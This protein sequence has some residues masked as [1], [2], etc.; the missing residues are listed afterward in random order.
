MGCWLP[1]AIDQ[2]KTQAHWVWPGVCHSTQK[3]LTD[4]LH[5]RELPKHKLGLVIARQA[6][7]LGPVKLCLSGPDKKPLARRPSENHVNPLPA[8]IFDQ[9]IRQ[10]F[11]PYLNI[12]TRR[13]LR[14]FFGFD[15]DPMPPLCVLDLCWGLVI[16]TSCIVS[17][18]GDP[19]LDKH[20]R[21]FCWQRQYCSTPAGTLF[22]GLPSW[23]I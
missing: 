10:S 20:P 6:A 5:P 17:A 2:R 11:A 4:S 13:I 22:P 14:P 9:R 23:P 12:P 18:T 3:S 16:V 19:Y 7:I 21:T 15:E 1:H 8:V